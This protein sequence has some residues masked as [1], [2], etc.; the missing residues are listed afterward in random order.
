LDALS[1]KQSD[2]FLTELAERNAVFGEGRVCFYDAEDITLARIAIHSEE[3]I[4]R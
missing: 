2:D 3:E 1:A 4:W